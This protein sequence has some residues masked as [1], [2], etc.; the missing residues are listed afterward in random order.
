M[1]VLATNQVG[2]HN[3]VATMGTSLTPQHI[4]KLKR[5]S[6]KVIICYDG[7]N[8]GLEGAKTSRRNASR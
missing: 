8:A 2:I 6:N 5:L 4:T 1:D 7:D 3:A